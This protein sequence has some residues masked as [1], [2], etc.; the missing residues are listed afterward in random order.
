MYTYIKSTTKNDKNTQ[1][2][3]KIKTENIKIIADSKY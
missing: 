2:V 1:N 3:T